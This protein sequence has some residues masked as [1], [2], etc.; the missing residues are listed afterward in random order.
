ME[1]SAKTGE[2]DKEDPFG[3]IVESGVAFDTARQAAAK[4][5][6]VLARMK[7][8]KVD[9][10]AAPE[11]DASFP[12]DARELQLQLLVL[13]R[14][15]RGMVRATEIGRI[16]EAAARKACDAEHALLETRRYESACCRAAARRCRQIP[17]PELSKLRP[18]LEGNVPE[19]EEEE[20]MAGQTGDQTASSHGLAARLQAE[21]EERSRLAAELSKFETV[22]TKAV[23]GFRER[24][25]LSVELV[26][27]LK[28]VEATLEPV[29]NL[30][31]VRPRPSDSGSPEGLTSLPASLRLV[32]SKFDTLA[33]FGTNAGVAVKIEV[34]QSYEADSADEKR[35]RREGQSAVV[36]EISEGSESK[37]A[38]V[39]KFLSPNT[40]LVTVA[41]KGPEGTALLGKLWP[42]DDGNNPALTSLLPGD[43]AAAAEAMGRPY[44]WAQVLAGLR[45]V[46][47]VAAPA[48]ANLEAVTATDV[49]LKV[50]AALRA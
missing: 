10:A 23:E 36:V 34:S 46:S 38:F 42:E 14:A 30:L 43:A 20:G 25:R 17:T 26:S 2:T 27:R 41:A 18:L 28:A 39:L 7:A 40:S 37:E 3:L 1:V 32:Y 47:L 33:A 16:A 12:A 13:R 4:I 21:M 6:A 48:F 49:V 29:C 5:H 22:K 9:G 15:H 19:D 24:E 8:G 35:R 44:G 31:Q 50:R 11:A 45:E